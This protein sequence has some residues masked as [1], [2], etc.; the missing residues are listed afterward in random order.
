MVF[1]ASPGRSIPC[2][3]EEIAHLESSRSDD[4]CNVATGE[5]VEQHAPVVTL[6]DRQAGTIVIVGRA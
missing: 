2:A 5:A 3:W 1:A 4:V 6:A